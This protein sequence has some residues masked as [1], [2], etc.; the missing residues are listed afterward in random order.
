LENE[1][2][3][4]RWIIIEIY[5]WRMLYRR[6]LLLSTYIYIYAVVLFMYVYYVRPCH[7]DKRSSTAQHSTAQHNPGSKVRLYFPGLAKHNRHTGAKEHHHNPPASIYS[8]ASYATGGQ[9]GTDGAGIYRRPL[10]LLLPCTNTKT[11]RLPFFFFFHP[12]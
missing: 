11:L 9:F 8:L 3:P 5:R 1:I 2:N 12:P 6:P 10:L 7:K 4:S